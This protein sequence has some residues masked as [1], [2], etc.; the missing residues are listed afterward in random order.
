MILTVKEASRVLGI[1]PK[2]VYYLI[3][4]GYIEGWKIANTWRI[5]KLSVETYAQRSILKSA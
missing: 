1:P 3:Y 5:S 2:N 4:M